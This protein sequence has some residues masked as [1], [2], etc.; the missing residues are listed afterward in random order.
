MFFLFRGTN[1]ENRWL[2]WASRSKALLGEQ[3]VTRPTMP[4]QMKG[5]SAEAI[6][7]RAR[8]SAIADSNRTEIDLLEG[9]VGENATRETRMEVFTWLAM[10]K[11]GCK[12]AG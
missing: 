5:D 7:M 10:N 2:L 11:F 12:V 1:S 9:A 8:L 6:A 4:K 3:V